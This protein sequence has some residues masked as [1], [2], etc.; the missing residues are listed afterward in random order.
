MAVPS[1]G[2]AKIELLERLVKRERTARKQAERL[3]DAKSIELFD[4]N[5]E[6]RALAKDLEARVEM[7]TVSLEIQNT[8]LSALLEN[9]LI[10]VVYEGQ[11]S[12]GLLYNPAICSLLGLNASDFDSAS[13]VAQIF[14]QLGDASSD[15]E[16]LEQLDYLSSLR[17]EAHDIDL[18]FSED[19][20]LV[21]D[22]IPVFVGDL[23]RGALWTLR[24]VTDDR[25][26][27]AFLEDARE[28]AE[29]GARAKSTFLAN[30]SHEIRTPL[31]GICGM[32]RLLRGE[33]LNNVAQD[34]VRAIQMSGDS[35]LHVLNDILDFS[36]V[37]AN[38]LELETVEFEMSHVLDS[39]FAV[40]QSQ[41]KSKSGRF[42]FVYPEAHLPRLSG[43]P[44]RLSEILVNL[45]GNALKFADGGDIVLSASVKALGAKQAVVE[46]V[47]KDAGI[48]MT[49]EQ[50]ERVFQPFSQADS[51]TSRR[52]GGTGLGLTICRDLSELMGG[53]LTV[54]SEAGVGSAFTLQMP[55]ELADP[56]AH[57][58]DRSIDAGDRVVVSTSSDVF[59][60]SVRTI[61]AKVGVCAQRA[62]GEAELQQRLALSG[63][64][65]SLVI[66]DRVEADAHGWDD[67]EPSFEGELRRLVVC[68]KPHRFLPRTQYEQALDYPFSRFKMLSAVHML[69]EASLPPGLFDHYDEYES[70]AVDL[71]GLRILMAEDNVINQ[72]V[73]RI[74]IE[75]F[76]AAVDLASNGLEAVEMIQ[77]FNY[78]LVL[79]DI[80][81]P[82]MD[83]VEAT[84]R[85]RDLGYD[86]P[87]YALTADAMK[88]DRERFIAAGMSG[89]LSKPLVEK[90]LIEILVAEK[91]RVSGGPGESVATA[92]EAVES[93]RAAAEGAREFVEGDDAII[94]ELDRF[95]E[96]LGGDM[97]IVGSILGEFIDCAEVYYAEAKAAF[98]KGDYA[99]TR[100]RFHKLAG[101]CASVFASQL[102]LYALRGEQL[103]IDEVYDVAT[104]ATLF[105]AIESGLPKL[106]V[107]I[108]QV[109][110]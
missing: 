64:G 18:Y 77:R 5:Q 54:E 61:L 95:K 100:S 84:E 49:P 107:E 94:L 37:E 9:I 20:Q 102:R 51:S 66:Y 34:Y 8:Q 11:S 48:G 97:E 92:V 89:Y 15:P 101:S 96:L 108:E 104:V 27:A 23:Y 3:L 24:D 33:P 31:N 30:M 99:V 44:S 16:L 68:R 2:Q 17:A 39:T 43:D 110:N 65:H 38:Q 14:R 85:I 28:Q 25:R 80:R 46:L 67:L 87:V 22:R 4:V 60:D 35:L 12:G 103:M 59:F 6:L 62:D 21:V 47:V 109:T 75:R 7:R 91:S 29:A 41:A 82:D 55:Y 58:P 26:Q 83:G 69:M 78:D 10:G 81:M 72:K 56:Q 93:T 74:T 36:K 63:R 105:A 40:L 19:R 52:F 50:V 13:S 1:E 88:G 71:T 53:S 45:L 106:R 86:L 42:D 70:E 76:G 90:D 79:M 73:G 32:A 98:E 57:L